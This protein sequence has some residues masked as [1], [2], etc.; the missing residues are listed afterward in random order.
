MQLLRITLE[1]ELLMLTFQVTDLLNKE[2]SKKLYTPSTIKLM[3]LKVKDKLSTINLLI[4]RPNTKLLTNKLNSIFQ[5]RSTFHNLSITEKLFITP[6]LLNSTEE[7]LDINKKILNT[8]NLS[9]E[10]PAEYNTKRDLLLNIIILRLFNLPR[11][12]K[13]LKLT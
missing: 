5:Q 3:L 7:L 13:K 4:K 2:K 9:T 6:N 8:T 12:L 1:L 11:L 10:I